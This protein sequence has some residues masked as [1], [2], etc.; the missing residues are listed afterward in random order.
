MGMDG[1]LPSRRREA[2]WAR[3]RAHLEAQRASGQ[4]QK[5]YCREHELCP[6]Q[7][8]VWK[9]RMKLLAPAIKATERP[10]LQ[11]VPVV[12]RKSSEVDSLGADALTLQ[13]RLPNALSVSLSVPTVEGLRS[14]LEQLAAVRC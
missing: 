3:W 1:S 2:V 7:F 5:D 4:T 8:S 11:L 10:A 9:G 6:R 14:V 13:L 12:I